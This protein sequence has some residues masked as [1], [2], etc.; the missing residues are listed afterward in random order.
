MDNNAI[1]KKKKPAVSWHK[2]CNKLLAKMKFA[3]ATWNDRVSPVMDTARNLTVVEYDEDHEISR[4]TLI[5]PQM[6]IYGRTS[7]LADL[8]IEYLICGAI[9]RH[10]ELL[11]NNFRV[12]VMAWICGRVNDVIEAFVT[13]DLRQPCFLLPGC[14]K[15]RARMRYRCGWNRRSRN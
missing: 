5:L 13:G 1:Q 7:F 3:I 12:G 2:V 6:E 8:E 14:G 15:N 11:L 4:Q 10:F 9:S